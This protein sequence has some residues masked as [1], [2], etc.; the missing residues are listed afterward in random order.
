MEH[1]Y[2]Y[3]MIILIKTSTIP[4][5]AKAS[6]ELSTQAVKGCIKLRSGKFS[7]DNF[8]RVAY[9]TATGEGLHNGVLDM[10]YFKSKVLPAIRSVV[11]LCASYNIKPEEISVAATAVYREASNCAEIV[12]LVERET[13]INMTGFTPD[14]EA[15]G[16][17]TITGFNKCTNLDTKDKYVVSVDLGGGSTEIAISKNGK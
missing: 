1:Q 10:N 2:L 8:K 6:M 4:G 13:G 12:D 7:F 14:Q 5:G 15:L 16:A 11:E 17:I 9:H 3:Y